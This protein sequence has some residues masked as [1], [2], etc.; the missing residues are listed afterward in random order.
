MKK[1]EIFSK[2]INSTNIIVCHINLEKMNFKILDGYKGTDLSFDEFYDYVVS[3]H[4]IANEFRKSFL[5]FFENLD[6]SK[7]QYEIPVE[8]SDKDGN[9]KTLIYT[10]M[11]VNDKE[12]ILLIRLQVFDNSNSLDE[13]T[14]AHSKNYIVKKVNELISLDISFAMLIVD[15]D[16]FKDLNDTYG[17]AFGD[18]VLVEFVSA[19]KK[20]LGSDGYIARIG[21]DEFL[22]LVKIEDDYDKVHET[23]AEI[24]QS[25][26]N[27]SNVSVQKSNI[28]V[29]IGSAQYPSD[30]DSFDLLFR[31]CDKALYRGKRKGRNCFVMYTVEKCGDVSL[32]DEEVATKEINNLSAK[33]DVFS[34]ITAVNHYLNSSNSDNIDYVINSA[35]NIIGN[36]YY[37]DRISMAKLD[38]K[39]HLISSHNVWHNPIVVNKYPPLCNEEVK[40]LWAKALGEKG[41]ISIGST[42]I[43]TDSVLYNCF[44]EDH[45]TASLAI[46]LM[47]NNVSY[48]II[49]FEMTTGT[50]HWQPEDYQVFSLFA[51]IFATFLNKN[52]LNEIAYTNMYMDLEYNCFNYTKFYKE[53]AEHVVSNINEPYS[54]LCMV[55]SDYTRVTSIIGKKKYSEI[56]YTMINTLN[57]FEYDDI[58]YGKRGESAFYVFIPNHN[59]ELIEKIYNKVNTNVNRY[60]EKTNSVKVFIQ[61]GAVLAD[62][63][64]DLNEVIDYVVLTRKENR[65]HKVLY[66]S[67]EI[68]EKERFKNELLINFDN[69]IKNNEF[70]LYLQPKIST[71]TRE[72]VGAEALTR[73][74]YNGKIL[75]PDT[76]IPILEENA[77]IETL[78]FEVFRNVCKFQAE[79]I[80][81]NLKPVPISVNVSRY[82]ANFSDYITKL[83]EIRNE[84]K[85]GPELFEIE[86]TEGMYYS[87]IEE[88][89]K[90]IDDLHSKNYK[91]SM[92]DFGS[93]YSN[94]ISLSTLNF[95]TIKLDKSFCNNLTNEKARFM[96][97]KIMEILKSLNMEALCEGVETLE[98]VEYLTSVGCDLIQG[99][100]FDRP[101]EHEKFKEKYIKKAQ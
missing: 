46:E 16:N 7:G 6:L 69:A 36:Y 97:L 49:R 21:G 76:F 33:N 39:T 35:F 61:S 23:C 11:P 98:N 66:Y 27:V 77:L 50:R 101:I 5:K 63:S 25:I 13:L 19:V 90:F 18:V 59:K 89:A 20:L 78:D 57:S 41:Y 99:Y 83:D 95:D 75:F 26:T 100:Y 40:P 32:D 94:F 1:E 58:L 53:V 8:Y 62:I 31:K 67:E 91:V 82:V 92:D 4:N 71:K 24:K 2:I 43:E 34:V 96:I 80:K 45:T 73:W 74:K 28:T 38:P 44:M 29:T 9:L 86:I 60:L 70:V 52:Y 48:G 37:L 3:K 93:G 10:G 56:I 15:I 64:Q 81:N 54:I 85:L 12:L 84:F 65:N 79:L 22:V 55:I 87:N 17:H 14:K 47:L 88:I 51:N 30:G 42:K 68:L 72:V